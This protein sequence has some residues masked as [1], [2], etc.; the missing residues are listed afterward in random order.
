VSQIKNCKLWKSTLLGM[1]DDTI[2][3]GV[4]KTHP[5]W[6]WQRA[7][8]DCSRARKG[9]HNAGGGSFI[10]GIWAS[11]LGGG[12]GGECSTLEREMGRWGKGGTSWE[13]TARGV[14]RKTLREPRGG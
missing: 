8:D 4:L 6:G 13:G 2:Q 9:Q 12:V 5:A 11:M 1:G 14:G 10:V 7:R 3:W